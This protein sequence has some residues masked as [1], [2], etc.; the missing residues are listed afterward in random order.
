MSLHK[1]GLKRV[2]FLRTENLE[3][4]KY[5]LKLIFATVAPFREN[6]QSRVLVDMRVAVV[7]V[8][9]AL[10]MVQVPT[11]ELRS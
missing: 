2:F 1:V 10:V 8:V 9:L 11:T 4:L 3:A 6:P 5:V 7:V